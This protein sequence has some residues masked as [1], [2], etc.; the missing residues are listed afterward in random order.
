MACL[1]GPLSQY[2]GGLPGA[3][4]SWETWHVGSFLTTLPTGHSKSTQELGPLNEPK[5]A[6]APA[7]WGST[8]QI[9][10]ESWVSL[11]LGSPHCTFFPGWIQVLPAPSCSSSAAPQKSEQIVLSLVDDC[12][13]SSLTPP[14]YPALADRSVHNGLLTLPCGG[15][16]SSAEPAAGVQHNHL[17]PQPHSE[18]ST[19]RAR[20]ESTLR[21]EFLATSKDRS[22]AQGSEPCRALLWPSLLI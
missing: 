1:K 13:A 18:R 19:K 3:R 12:G 16:P 7:G 5:E 2:Q 15:G 21:W 11:G 4:P 10:L 17:N 14:H 9:G 20:R 6:E 8:V 22:H